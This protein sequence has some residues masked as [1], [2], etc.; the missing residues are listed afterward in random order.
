MKQR[1][2]KRIMTV[3]EWFVGDDLARELYKRGV[4]IPFDYSVIDG[5]E[6]GSDVKKGWK[7]FGGLLKISTDL[8]PT[9]KTD[10]DGKTTIANNFVNSVWTGKMSIDALIADPN[11][12]YNDGAKNTKDLHPDYDTS[13]VINP[14]YN[15]KKT[16]RL[17]DF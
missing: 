5:I 9:I 13:T 10:T 11:K 15:V 2:K 12:I 17:M 16:G 1:T 4:Q 3:F 7:E 14:D 6:L 8:S